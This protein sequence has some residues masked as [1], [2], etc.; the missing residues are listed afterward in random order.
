MSIEQSLA[1]IEKIQ[2]RIAV[3][4]EA[5]AGGQ[6]ALNSVVKIGTADEQQIYQMAKEQAEPGKPGRGKKTPPPVTAAEAPPSPSSASGAAPV[7]PPAVIVPT[8]PVATGNGN[9]T[10]LK[11]NDVRDAALKVLTQRFKGSE[12]G[13]AFI[14]ATV[15]TPF[16]LNE[17]KE[18]ESRP[19]L[20]A[21]AMAA[22]VNATT[23]VDAL[24]G[25]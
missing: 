18:M 24:A 12:E 1:N 11:F 8:A 9:G 2:E 22:L 20:W 19:E 23:P 13:K 4:L 16:G 6:A 15:V 25:I 7:A 21:Q 3:A 14:K 5:M 17:L 10:A